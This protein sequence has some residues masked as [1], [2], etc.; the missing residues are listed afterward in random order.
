MSTPRNDNQAVI[1]RFRATGGHVGGPNRLLLLTTI[2]ARS[3]QPRTTPVAYSTDDGRFVIQASNSGKPNHPDW[4]HNLLANP[5][6]TVDLGSE[7]FPAHAS[8]AAGDERERLFAQHVAQMPGFAAYQA[9]TS[10]QIP[11]VILERAG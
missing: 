1:E 6:V 4:Y 7:Q 2:G 10:R 9:N 3:G 5:Q 8:V 11:V